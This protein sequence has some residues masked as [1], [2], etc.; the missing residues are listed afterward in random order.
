MSRNKS[1][2][3]VIEGC[4][5]THA[6]E[7]GTSTFGMNPAQLEKV[8][9]GAAAL[10]A[11]QQQDDGHWVFDLE[12]DVTIPAEYAMLQ[13]F[14]GREIDSGIA[15]RLAVYMQERQLP[16]GGWPLHAVDGNANISASVKAYFASSCWGTTRTPPT[17]SGRAS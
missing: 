7:G 11:G 3:N 16:D 5:T 12:A 6:K 9:K 2:F 13:R 14:I 17:W 8:T 4:K 10:L 15:E 1:T